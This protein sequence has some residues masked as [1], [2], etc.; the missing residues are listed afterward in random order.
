MGG[1]G[2]E[3][4]IVGAVGCFGRVRRLVRRRREGVEVWEADGEVGMGSARRRMLARPMPTPDGSRYA[5]DRRL[6]GAEFVVK[7]IGE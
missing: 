1:I 7:G 3:G 5:C 2:G 4:G 6:F